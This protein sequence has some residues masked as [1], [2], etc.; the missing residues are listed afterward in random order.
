[1]HGDTDSASAACQH[2]LNASDLLIIPTQAEF[3]S[4]YALQ[5]MFTLIRDVRQENNPGLKYRILVTLL[6]LRLRDH[7][8]MLNQLKKYLGGS[9]YKTMISVDT[10]F[11][12]SHTSGVPIN[13]LEPNTRGAVQYREL[14]QEMIKDL[15][16]ENIA[17]REQV[18]TSESAENY[19]IEPN[20][21]AKAAT[22]PT[23]KDVSNSRSKHASQAAPIKFPQEERLHE[24]SFCSFLGKDED[25]QTVL[26]YPSIWNKCHL[27]KPV[28]SPS[29]KH[30]NIYCLSNDFHSCPMMQKTRGGLP[31]HL[32]A[33]MEK[34]EYFEYFKNWI[35]A[36]MS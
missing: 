28:V 35:R 19:T 32:R 8:N 25:P 31:S 7:S 29:L 5:K 21:R 2:A 9:L 33:P 23:L 15:E 1:V 26:A 11:R 18:V 36:I 10:N 16:G 17:V 24:G 12:K 34:A 4:A 22:S 20:Q 13:Y 14:A 6:D 30:Q 27:A 3:F